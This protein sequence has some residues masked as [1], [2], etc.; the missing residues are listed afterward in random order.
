[1]K[2]GLY[3]GE[4]A[5]SS[6][7]SFGYDVGR[8][9]GAG[10]VH[11][12][13]TTTK[14]NVTI[15]DRYDSTQGTLL[16]HELTDT[17][18][19]S[20]NGQTRTWTYTYDG[21]GELLTAQT[22][23]TDVTVKTT[24]TYTSGALASI[25][26]PLSN[27]TTINTANGT[28][29]PTKITDANSV[30]TDLAY[31]AR[32]HL[33][34]KTVKAGTNEVTS[35]SYY[36]D[37]KLDVVTLP[38]SGPDTITYTYDN[39]H[40]VTKVTNGASETMNYTLDAMGDVTAWNFKNGS[41]TTEK[42][43]SATFDVLGDKL[44]SVGS[45]GA[46]QTTTFTY[47]GNK[48]RLSVKDANSQ[49][50]SLAWDAL[51]RPSTV[52][53]PYSHTAAPTYDNLDNITAQTDF[54]GYSTSF[55]FDGFHDPISKTSP[56]TGTATFTFDGD[57][58]VTKRV[59]ARSVETDR[60]F[61]KL[62][63]PTA[64]TYPSYSSEAIA[65][66]YDATA[67]GNVGIGRL[68][69]LTDES[70]S[71]TFVYDNFGNV[72]SSVRVIGTQTYTTSYS[73]DL[74]NRVT[75]IVYPS[76]RIVNYT[77]STSGYLTQVDTKPTS[78]GTDTVLA[79]SIT[80]QPFGPIASLTYGNTLSQTN[81]YDDNYWLDD[82][83]T[84]NGSTHI[85]NL[86]YAQDYAGNLTSITDNLA[87]GRDETYTVD[88]LNRLHTAS[89]AYGSRTYTY[90]NNGNRSTWYNGTITRTST[91][92]TSTN[93]LASITDGTNTRH[94]TNSASG[95]VLTDD[96]VMNG[97]VAISNTYGGRDR[98]ESMAVGTPT[99]TF[100][101]NALGQR[102]QKATTSAT[103]DYLYDLAGHM[104]GE[105][106]DSTGSTTLEYIFME[107]KLLAQVDSSGNI[108]YSHDNQVGA[109]QKITNSSMTI[110]WDYET[111]PFGETYATPTNTDPTNHR[112]PGQYADAED[113]L[114][115][116][117]NR[118]YDTTLGR[119]IEADP[120]GLKAGPNVFGYAGQN[121]AEF[122]DPTG[123][124]IVLSTYLGHQTVGIVNPNWSYGQSFRPLNSAYPLGGQ[125]LVY[126]D[127]ADLNQGA[128]NELFQTTPDE[129]NYAQLYFQNQLDYQQSHPAPTYW[130]IGG[131]CRDYSQGQFHNLV[132]TI[133]EMRQLQ[134]SLP[135]ETPW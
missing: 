105:A 61:D 109:P 22:P 97:A 95:N 112:F 111:E 58:N 55:T 98:L 132:T 12:P 3:E 127:T 68:T 119:Y 107:G 24:Y 11:K 35:Y 130:L 89:G 34:S 19:G 134:M 54:D 14:T 69:S 41:S 59:D 23:R 62:E 67:G 10:Q 84:S 13:Y 5:E 103:T 92:T 73:Y 52:T 120:L 17:T 44:T 6:E 21:T 86:T 79:S 104:I 45:A 26:D 50:T 87:A 93:L 74:A 94:F 115:Y 65:Y 108:Y 46:T 7:V 57:H 37:E 53:D 118:D 63:R 9:R 122:V 91:L 121:P 126:N 101:I 80:H 131:S 66:T 60:T 88:D 16:T 76:G 129:D 75:Q 78:G 39:A 48:N 71:T 8:K 85:Q 43:G 82:I 27:V 40:R 28:G 124:D 32:N 4:A 125:G 128:V 70:G 77:Y 110:V 117:M 113:L 72:T 133:G 18:G 100:K 51:N 49:T 81:T 114:S 99:I 42:S 96:R 20:T 123:K 30:E 2:S 116:N 56:D 47:D 90:D 102:V 36:A 25:T 64:E 38:D 135:I 29:Q 33:T 31:D 83:V 15:D 1:M 106:N